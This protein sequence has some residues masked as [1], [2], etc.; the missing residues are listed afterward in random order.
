MN[1]RVLAEDVESGKVPIVE[2]TV[3]STRTYEIEVAMFACSAEPCYWG[4]KLYS[5]PSSKTE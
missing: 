2:F 5:T 4:V 3:P 1:S